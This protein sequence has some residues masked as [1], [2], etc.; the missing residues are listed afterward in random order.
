MSINLIYLNVRKIG[1]DKVNQMVIYGDQTL[2]LSP[3]IIERS[4]ERVNVFFL[5]ELRKVG[6]LYV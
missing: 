4:G 5:S 3:V 1:T 2:T 6:D